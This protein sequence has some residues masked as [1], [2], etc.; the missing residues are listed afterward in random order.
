MLDAVSIGCCRTAC[1]GSVGIVLPF[2]L[3]SQSRLE[4]VA[5]R[6]DK[7]HRPD[8]YLADKTPPLTIFVPGRLIGANPPF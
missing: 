5:L 3:R 8:Y 1:F 2:Q 6:C 4:P 7:I